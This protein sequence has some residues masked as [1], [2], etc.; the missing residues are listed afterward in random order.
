MNKPLAAVANNHSNLGRGAITRVVSAIV[1]ALV[2]LTH[3]PQRALA[4][5]APERT[6]GWEFIVSS[7]G[8]IPTGIQRESIGR[9]ALTSAQLSRT[10]RP[11]L[12][13]TATL[14]WARSRD[15]RSNGDNALDVFDYDLGAEW[16]SAG[17]AVGRAM[18]IRPF[19]GAGAGGR[20]YDHRHLPLESTDLAEAYLGAGGE[21]G[22]RRL[23]LRLEARDYLSAPR[24]FSG[25][26]T[27]GARNDL[28]LMAGLRWVSR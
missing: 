13:L 28:A 27:D 14:G 19:V 20:H 21:L 24:P 17:W 23:R 26:S 12:A 11:A 18:T 15:L 5:A 6:T 3:S 10:V 16:R 1:G 2:L 25:A 7:G 4:Q 22:V 9:G 8:L